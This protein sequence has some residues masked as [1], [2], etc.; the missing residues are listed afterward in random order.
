MNLNLTKHAVAI[1]LGSAMTVSCNTSDSNFAVPDIENISRI[2]LSDKNN[3]IVLSKNE[4]DEWLNSSFKAN[5]PNILNL[6]KILSDIEIRYPLPKTFDSVYSIKK[7]MDEGILIKAFNGKK[8]TKSYHLLFTGD[9]NATTVGLMSG[10]QKPY[11]VE[12]PGM[13]IDF[14]DYI[15]MESAFWEN[16]ILFSSNQGQI[17]YLKIENIEDPQNSFS[18]KMTDSISLF[19]ING[20]NIP[21]NKSGMEQYLSYFN[22]ISFEHNLNIQEEEKQKIISSP[23]LYIM[24]VKREAD[25]ATCFITPISDKGFDDYGNPLV[26][27]RDYFYLIVPQKNL[28]AKARWLKFDILL[29][30]LNCLRD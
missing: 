1:L 11:I 16:N 21:F 8:I 22:N 23:P 27:C 26:Y 25:S 24:T 28:F 6:K 17:K 2:E 13:D 30:D 10:K 14:S 20:T 7:I 12:L 18:I 29:E 9:E 5:M 15:V 3:Y 19:D 4:N